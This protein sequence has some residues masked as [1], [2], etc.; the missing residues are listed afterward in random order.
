MTEHQ[1]ESIPWFIVGQPIEC[2]SCHTIVEE[3]HSYCL[4]KGKFY[5]YDCHE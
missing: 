1:K 4:D 5:C 2:A 3:G